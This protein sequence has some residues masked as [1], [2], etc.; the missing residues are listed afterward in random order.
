MALPPLEVLVH[1]RL[2]FG[3]RPGDLERFRTLAQNPRDA[4]KLWLERQLEPQKIPD[5]AL[6]ARLEAFKTLKKSQA[7]LWIEHRRDVPD[8]PESYE[9]KVLPALETRLAT[10][11]RA[12]WSERQ[13][14]E[15]MADFWHNHFNI[16]P[17]RDEAIAALFASFD[18]DVIRANVFGNFRVLLEGVVKHPCMLFYLDNASNQRAGP[19]ENFA[20]ELFELHTMGAE[21]YLGIKRQREVRGFANGN[22]VGYVDDDIYEATRC[23]TG[24]RVADNDEIGNTGEFL[25]YAA[26]H[27]RFQKTVLGKFMPADQAPQKDGRDVLDTLASHTGTAVYIC[28]KLCRRLIADTPS[29]NIVHRA[30]KVFLEQQNAPDQLKHVLRTIVYSDEFIQT[31]GSKVKR[32]LERF[33]S[34]TRALETEFKLEPDRQWTLE[35]LGQMPFNHPMPDG[36][37]D[38]Q[39]HWVSSTSLLRFWSLANGFAHNWDESY[40]S[41][42]LKTTAARRTP[43][44]IANFWFDRILGRE[45]PTE[46]RH[47]VLDKLRDNASPNTP[48]PD[49]AL[50]WR[51]TEEVGLILMSPE[52]LER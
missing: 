6:E 32:P 25:Y 46:L 14:L 48:I 50:E 44:E 9:T 24:W 19:N 29:E 34:L 3:A 4:L 39:E 16:D 27:D 45:P 38:T 36:Y 28:R 52:F 1:T 2:A 40:R 17:G 35:W 42:V 5:T 30:A 20:R 51:V 12:I 11:A 33:Y 15:V 26:W 8:G 43:N 10:I 37:P 13:L 49:D 31:W 41:S 22:P 23:F 7:K 21:H 47:A 18:R